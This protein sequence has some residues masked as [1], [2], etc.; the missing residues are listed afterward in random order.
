V[1]ELEISMSWRELR[2]WETFDAIHEPLPDR[3]ADIHFSMI[4]A[5]IV[6]L[7]RNADSDPVVASEF[8]VI[9]N[10]TPTPPAATTDIDTLRA[11]WR[12]E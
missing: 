4:A 1:D 3:L 9:K 10:R 2:A 12:G 11:Q 5:L 6:N 7:M 8:F